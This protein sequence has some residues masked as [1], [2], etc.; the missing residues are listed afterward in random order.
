MSTIVLVFFNF[1][2]P[3]NQNEKSS[4]KKKKLTTRVTDNKPLKKKKPPLLPWLQR[5][6]INWLLQAYWEID[7]RY[8][9][10]DFLSMAVRTRFAANQSHSGNYVGIC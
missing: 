5:G 7:S 8:W 10:I 9:D 2:I 4:Q 3:L 6:R 1:G